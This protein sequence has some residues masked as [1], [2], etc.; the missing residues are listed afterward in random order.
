MKPDIQIALEHTPTPI[1]QIVQEKLGLTEDDLIPYG[2]YIAKV[3]LPTLN[4]LVA[5]KYRTNEQDGKLIVVTAITPTRA[6]EGKTVTTIGLTQ[7]LDYLGKRAQATIRQ[8]SMGPVFGVKGGATGGGM[9]QVYPMWKI[10]L[11]FT[12]DI[13]AVTSA[14]NLLSALID[15]H[16][17]KDNR[18]NIDPTK[19]TWLRALDMNDRALRKILIG[20]GGRTK[21]GLPREDGFL[22]TAASEIMSVLA[23]SRN[24]SE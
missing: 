19:V 3:T 10:D 17:A 23:L 18:L 6:G 7:S 12:G 2:N 20:L 24:I 16:L 22:I 1:K 4:N 11:E 14:H 5:G 21:G 15:N 13:H 9:S 8:P